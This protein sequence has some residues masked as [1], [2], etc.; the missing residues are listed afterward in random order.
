MSRALVGPAL[1]R[2]RR[3]PARR[4]LPQIAAKIWSG[5]LVFASRRWPEGQRQGRSPA[6]HRIPIRLWG[7]ALLVLALTAL[8][9]PA[10]YHF[11]HY[12]NESS[13]TVAVPEKFDLTALPY[14]TATIFVSE[15]GPLEYSA[16]DNFNSVLTQLSQATQVW[17][18][19][20]TSD[21]RVAFGGLENANTS[22]NT[23]GGDVVFEDLPPGIYG[24]GG[25]TSIAYLATAADGSKFVPIL[26]STI[27]LNVNMT[28]LPGPSYNET[29]FMVAVHEIGHALGL[30]HTFTSSTMSQATTRA[31]NLTHP[32]DNDDIAGLSVLYPTAAGLA[33]FGSITGQITAGGQGVHLASVVAIQ[34][35]TGAVSGVTNPDGTYRIDGVPPGRYTVY[36][37][38]MPPDADICGPWVGLTVGLSDTGCSA[39]V[40]AADETVL[41]PTA[42]IDSLF[43]V[44]GGAASMSLAQATLVTVTAGNVTADIDIAS[45]ARSNVELYDDVVYSYLDNNTVGP[46]QPAEVQIQTGTAQVVATGI[47]LGSNG[48]APGLGVQFMGPSL[49]LQSD[50]IQPYPYVVNGITYT[51]V[52]LD[53][54]FN[55]GAV[56]GF[57][58]VVFNTPDYMYVLPSGIN[59]T[60]NPPPTVTGATANGDGTVT[61]TGTN[62]ASDTLLY[63]D[64]LPSTIVSLDPVKGSS[65]VQ[66]PPGINNQNAIVSAYNTDG[67]NSQYVQPSSPVV[68]SYGK[69]PASAITSISPSSLP[70]GAEATIDITTTGLNFT[71]G[72]T[73]ALTTVGFGTSDIL[74]QNIFASPNHLRVNVYVWP[75]AALSNPDVSVMAGF[76]LATATAGFQITA[77]AAG[78]PVPYPALFNALPP[79]T[80]A[81]PGAVVSLYGANLAAGSGTPSVTIA[82]QPVTVLYASAGQFNLLLPTTLTPG[83]ATLLLNN[84]AVAA[85]PITVNIDTLPAGIDAIQDSTNGAY[86]Y[87]GNPAVQGEMLVVLLSNFAPAGTNIALNRVSVSVGGVSHP[88]TKITSVESYYQIY[89]ALNPNDPVG[90]SEQLVVYLDGR[91]S[92]PATIPV[93]TQ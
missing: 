75:N 90:Q 60:L 63:F 73:A 5:P 92:Y 69:S 34:A 57:Q 54:G 93:D 28:L 18:G 26:R 83:P 81:Y 68:Y 48:Q 15:N 31:T 20:A 25:P 11:I 14:K 80:G 40:G 78:Q 12:I 62:W 82:G 76:Q 24:Y 52:A 23:P 1:R 32:V 41:A 67:Q 51:A 27:H 42:P 85:F 19:I 59:L 2:C 21:L 55:S 16:N 22:Q 71:T 13:G 89:F 88:V 43:Y 74:V 7:S 72:P 56:P 4:R 58:H 36:V 65:V 8:P 50:G 3:A 46:L 49:S 47:G 66:P 39:G 70:A 10:Y 53:L 35:G 45:T 38:T 44:N 84:G 29:F 37:H 79:M 64:G 30:Q 91:S 17:N 61:L 77:P 9:A 33:Q 86:I 6:P 87:A